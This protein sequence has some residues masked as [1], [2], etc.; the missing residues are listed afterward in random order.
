[1]FIAIGFTL[2]GFGLG[3]MIGI[4]I[5][6]HK[7]RMKHK[8]QEQIRKCLIGKD[9]ILEASKYNDAYQQEHEKAKKLLNL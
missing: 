5:G 6:M 7:E 8:E 2:L 9:D 4:I 1:M 3:F